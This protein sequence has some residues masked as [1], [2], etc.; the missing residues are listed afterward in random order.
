MGTR[1]MN[2]MIF[3]TKCFGKLLSNLF[4]SGYTKICANPDKFQSITL[5]WGGNMMTSSNGN[6]FVV[7]GQKLPHLN[8]PF[9][10]PFLTCDL[11]HSFR[12]EQWKCHTLA[13]PFLIWL[14]SRGAWSLIPQGR[15]LLHTSWRCIG[16][17]SSSRINCNPSMDKW[18][19]GQ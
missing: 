14:Q 3:F 19:R 18:W 1:E 12:L 8:N 4:L 2:I 15:T 16:Y 13:G 7:P 9:K 5:I 6:I 17:N 10:Q 11:R